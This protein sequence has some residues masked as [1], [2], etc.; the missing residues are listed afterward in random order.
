MDHAKG[1][2]H[3]R[4][5]F[6]EGNGAGGNNCQ[7]P[8]RRARLSRGTEAPKIDGVKGW[9]N[10]IGGKTSLQK[11]GGY[12]LAR[13]EHVIQ[14]LYHGE[15]ALVLEKRDWR[16]VTVPALMFFRKDFPE[17]LRMRIARI[18]ESFSACGTRKSKT[19]IRVAVARDHVL[20]CFHLLLHPLI[21]PRMH[22]ISKRF[23][24]LA[25]KQ[26]GG[27]VG[28]SAE[29]RQQFDQFGGNAMWSPPGAVAPHPQSPGP[30]ENSH[31]IIGRSACRERGDKIG[32]MQGGRWNGFSHCSALPVKEA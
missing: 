31:V 2:Q 18:Q 21:K 11:R 4:R 1:L 12:E 5:T 16:Q 7:R 24:S 13:R 30:K 19:R 25:R 14:I 9:E 27:D 17:S 3:I 26:F 22:A 6:A 10:P 20:A 8:T 15:G 32:R 29:G 23:R 28:Q